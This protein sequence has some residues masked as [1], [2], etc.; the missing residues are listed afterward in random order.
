MAL[1]G[2]SS[3]S[4]SSGSGSPE[5]QAPTRSSRQACWS[6]RDGY[7][8]CLTSK[9]IIVPPGTDMNDGRGPVGKQSAEETAKQAQKTKRLQ[10]D[11]ASDPCLDSRREYE[12]HCARSWIDYFNKRRVLEERQRLMYEQNKAPIGSGPAAGNSGK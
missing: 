6:G 2:D 4:S 12:K 11:L 10:E 3:S 5:Q 7:Y 9:S 8:A 1:F